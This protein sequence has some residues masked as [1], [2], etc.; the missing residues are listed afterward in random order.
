MTKIVCERSN[1]LGFNLV[2]TPETRQEMKRLIRGSKHEMDGFHS[3]NKEFETIESQFVHDYFNR[4]NISWS[5]YISEI[6]DWP[7]LLELEWEITELDADIDHDATKLEFARDS[8]RRLDSV[9]EEDDSVSN[10]ISHDTH[11]LSTVAELVERSSNAVDLGPYVLTFHNDITTISEIGKD[12]FW[13]RRIALQVRTW[14]NYLCTFTPTDATDIDSSELGKAILRSTVNI[15]NSLT[16]EEYT[17]LAAPKAGLDSRDEDVLA[18][19]FVNHPLSREMEK[20]LNKNRGDL[21]EQI[22]R[23]MLEDE[24]RI[25]K[26]KKMREKD[27]KVERLQGSIQDVRSKWEKEKEKRKQL[28]KIVEEQSQ[29]KIN[30][31]VSAE[32]NATATTEI[33]QFNAE[34]NEFIELLDTKLP[35]GIEQSDLP[36]PPED[37]DISEIEDWLEELKISVAASGTVAALEPLV[38]DLLQQASSLA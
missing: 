26:F 19:Y 36:N 7:R 3:G 13:E 33:Q 1:E 27:E 20:A 8:L 35:E 15:D 29:T 31:N 23:E 5:E 37:G 22:A 32:A 28:E 34:L 10:K 30:I 21:A 4:D 12:E 25:E 16:I 18:D 9:I 24:E 11:L 6:S 2:Y 38:A 17:R 14:L